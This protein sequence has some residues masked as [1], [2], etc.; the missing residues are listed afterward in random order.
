MIN[1]IKISLM[2]TDVDR[3]TE[4]EEHQPFIVRS[5][6]SFDPKLYFEKN[7]RDIT[8][9][10]KI[11]D[12]LFESFLSSSLDLIF[13]ELIEVT[14]HP[15]DY[16]GMWID[17]EDGVIDNSIELTVLKEIEEYSNEP[18]IPIYEFYKM[19]LLKNESPVG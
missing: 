10:S 14:N 15:V 13:R 17:T 3:F 5:S 6:G 1:K 12:E 9:D 8:P 2:E 19:T 18:V 4:I 11:N 16:V 7:Y